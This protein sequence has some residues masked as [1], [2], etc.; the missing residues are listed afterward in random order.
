VNHGSTGS[1]R[2]DPITTE[3]IARHVLAAAQEMG[4]TLMRT[5]FSPNIK[6]RHDCSTAVFDAAGQVVA[7]AEHVP[8]HLGSMIGAI[9]AIT[10]RWSESEISDGDMFVANDPYNG[11]GSHLPDLNV[12][13]PVFYA[14]HIVAYVASIAHHADVGGMVPGSESAVCESIYQEG[15]RLPPVRLVRNGQ[16]NPDVFD[17]I[18]LNS[19]TPDE[20]LGDLN[21]QLAANHVGIR[22]IVTLIERYGVELFRRALDSYLDYTERRFRAAIAALPDGQHTAEDFVSGDGDTLARIVCTVTVGRN[23][24]AFD[25]TGT[26]C[27]LKCARNVPH[28]ALVASIYTVAK[29]LLDPDAPANGGAFRVIDIAAPAGTLVQPVAPAPVGARSL[30]CG[31]LSD[32]ILSALSGVLPGK[33]MAASGPH[34]LVVFGGTD[35][36]T[37]RYFVNYETVAGGLGARGDRDGMD[38]VRTLTSGSANLPIEALEHAYPLRVERYALRAESG[39]DGTYRGGD[40]L[41]RDYRI[42]AD[43]VTVS[44]TGERQRVAAQGVES[45][46]PGATGQF[47]L[48]PD[49]ASERCLGAATNQEPV[50]RDSILRIATPGGGG[51]GLSSERNPDLVARDEREGR[52][53]AKISKNLDV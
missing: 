15:L 52:A 6:E 9:D 1:E 12:I 31:V 19:R 11:G 37:K 50:P 20:R 8:I 43:D 2:L 22:S 36:R 49:T 14:G 21:A 24:L 33:R 10:S 16:V 27:Q 48:N 3:V 13:A 25:F 39:G 51:F 18:A 7:Q 38:A 34:H 23:R 4:V 45:G 47:L 40:A 46:H 28:Q 5:A 32:V 53:T 42:L 26:S 35:P 41:V 30:T 17:I 44:L 29:V